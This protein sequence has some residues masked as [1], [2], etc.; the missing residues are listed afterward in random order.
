MV[1]FKEMELNGDE[2]TFPNVHET[3]K[4]Y[5]QWDAKFLERGKGRELYRKYGGMNGITRSDTR[6]IDWKNPSC[7]MI[8][9]GR[10]R[11]DDLGG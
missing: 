11:E 3:V 9:N 8:K 4:G 10:C 2:R 1:L 6:P 7:R 5:H